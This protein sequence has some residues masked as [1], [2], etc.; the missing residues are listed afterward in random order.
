ML[1]AMSGR[2]MIDALREV[3]TFSPGNLVCCS[4]TR[5]WFV[6]HHHSEWRRCQLFRTACRMLRLY[7]SSHTHYVRQ[8][9]FC[10]CWFFS[11]N[12]D[13]VLT[14]TWKC[15]TKLTAMQCSGGKKSKQTQ[16]CCIVG[17]H[18]RQKFSL[19]F[20]LSDWKACFLNRI[21]CVLVGV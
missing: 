5:R 3:D 1:V 16:Y 18:L 7:L 11:W 8:W 12:L 19:I 14:G 17:R 4:G 6:V 20:V 15:E 10:C 2:P 21:L 9:V 13:N